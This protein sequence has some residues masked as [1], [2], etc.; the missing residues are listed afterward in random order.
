MAELTSTSY[1]LEESLNYSKFARVN[2][3][4]KTNVS[5]NN[6]YSIEGDIQ[7][8]LE[9]S[10]DEEILKIN[11]TRNTEL[12]FP[13]F[14]TPQTD[15]LKI[16][17]TLAENSKA[18]LYEVLNTTSINQQQIEFNIKL[19]SGAKLEHITQQNPG[20][21]CQQLRKSHAIVSKDGSYSPLH[22]NLGGSKTRSE[23]TIKL[24]E[25]GAQAQAHAFYS[26]KSDQISEFATHIDHQV[27]HTESSQLYKG[28]LDDES[29]ALFNGTITVAPNA[30]Q[31]NSDQLNKNLLL[32][33]KAQ[34]IT[35]PQLLIDAD[36]VKCSHGATIGQLSDEQLFYLQSRG[37][38]KEKAYQFLTKAFAFEIA[39]KIEEQEFRNRI[40]TELEKVFLG[41]K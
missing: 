24:I 13:L 10:F 29:F 40:E 17:L 30:L 28:L 3:E 32:S 6:S 11:V 19:K 25:P 33:K 20:D 4:P 5:S 16:E 2:F 14:L 38:N 27:S 31:I 7:A 26:L 41:S 35:K 18:K 1:N 21:D 15:Q 23:N 9:I 22:F 34:V 8:G 39:Q 37:I 12:L 36:D